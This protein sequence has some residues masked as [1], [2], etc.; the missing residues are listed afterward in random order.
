MSF[1]KIGLLSLLALA[2]GVSFLSIILIQKNKP[3]A[4]VPRPSAF[5]GK[6]TIPAIDDLRVGSRKIL[7]CGVA[8]AKPQSIRA[9]VTE[10]ARRDYEGL[11]LKC[12]PVGTGTPCDGNVASK[13]GGAVV[14]QC[15]TPDGRDFAATLAENG[16]LCGQPAQAGST[17]KSCLSGS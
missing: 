17:Y 7:L 6:L 16:I 4:P 9:M 12:K 14:V 3:N 5:S 2:F 15:F 1:K 11:A 13:F 10:V 8:F